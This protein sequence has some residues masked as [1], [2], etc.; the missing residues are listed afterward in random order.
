MAESTSCKICLGAL[1]GRA[2]YHPA[3]LRGL[4]GTS[5]LPR[6][7]LDL[8]GVSEMARDMAGKM[9]ISGVQQKV[10]V[11]L[12][13]DRK[14]IEFKPTGGRY[15]L[16]PPI[17]GL[18]EIP[19]NEHVTMQMALL[20]GIDIPPC[21]LFALNDGNLAYVVS[22]FDRLDD[23]AKLQQEDFCQ[24]G[25]LQASE[26][27]D[28]NAEFCVKLLRQYASEPIISILALFR[29]LLFS[30]CVGNCD[31]HLK[32]LSLLTTRDRIRRLSPAYD[33]LS[34]KL[35]LKNQTLALPIGGKPEIEKRNDWVRFGEYC[36]IPRP[37]IDRVI[38]TQIAA[39]DEMIGMIHNSYLSA[40]F[41]EKY[42]RIVRRSIAGLAR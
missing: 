32:N 40:V 8:A 14:Q 10:L 11:S 12:T 38:S 37:A 25:G 30:S 6:L 3:C 41:K 4:F 39:G 24:A 27:Y 36:R 35:V 1:N 9:S 23:G 13:P 18:P 19:A 21:G 29:L 5:V 7:D 16:K 34:T 20:V 22:R 42:E 15:I 17:Q 33:L 31:L 26:K 28:K 2:E